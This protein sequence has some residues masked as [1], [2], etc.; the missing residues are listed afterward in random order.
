[1][2]GKLL[3]CLLKSKNMKRVLFIGSILVVLLAACGGAASLGNGSVSSQY[4][5]VM[6][7][8][9]PT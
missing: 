2:L 6:V 8:T 9:A 4:D 3:G 1:M 5:V 7:Y